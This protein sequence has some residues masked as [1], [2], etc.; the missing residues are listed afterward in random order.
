M[1]GGWDFTLFGDQAF[2]SKKLEL[3]TQP[4]L[5]HATRGAIKVVR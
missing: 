5:S 3:W 1:E 4:F 2:L